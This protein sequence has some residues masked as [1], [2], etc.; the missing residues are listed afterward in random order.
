MEKPISPDPKKILGSP[1]GP[2]GS[3]PAS[4]VMLCNTVLSDD[5]VKDGPM[6]RVFYLSF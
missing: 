6:S 3:N 4:A 5:P 2:H 1:M